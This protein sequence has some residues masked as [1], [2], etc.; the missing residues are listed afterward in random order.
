M[1]I[2]FAAF[3][4]ENGRGAASARDCADVH[5]IRRRCTRLRC[6]VHGRG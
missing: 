2:H 3:V 1:F 4:N 5:A 6:E